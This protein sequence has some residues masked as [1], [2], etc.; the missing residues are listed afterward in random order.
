MQ[1][2]TG[3]SSN[4]IMKIIS[5]VFV[6]STALYLSLTM[7]SA[8]A[9]SCYTEITGDN[10]TD[11]SS[12]DASALQYAI[13]AAASGDVIKVA[14][15]C[16]DSSSTT[17]VNP[18]VDISIQG[19]YSE[20]NWLENADPETNV[21]TLD[22]DNNGRIVK[23]SNGITLTLSGVVLSNVNKGTSD[24]GAIYNN[25]GTLILNDSTITGSD[26]GN[27]GA[28]FGDGSSHI[29]AEN[30]AIVDNK[31]NW[32][33]VLYLENSSTGEFVNST[34]SG[35]KTTNVNYGN[36]AGFYLD[37]T[38]SL[39][40]TAVTISNNEASQYG[41]AIFTT[42]SSSVTLNSTIIANNIDADACYQGYDSDTTTWTD[43]GY[44]IEST[45]TC[46]LS[47]SNSL[48]DTDPLLEALASNGGSTQTHA[49]KDDSPAID[50]I[51]AGDND[52]GYPMTTDQRGVR[53]PQ[54]NGCDIGA[55]EAD[56]TAA[57]FALDDSYSAALYATLN[58]EADA[59]LLSNDLGEN[60]SA[61]LASAASHG[62]VTVNSDGSFSYTADGTHQ[63]DDSF[64]Y[65]VSDG[66]DS[67]IATVSIS[68]GDGCYVETT[69]DD[70]SDDASN[71]ASALQNAITAASS[72]DVIKIAG[73]CADSSNSNLVNPS[74]DI[75]LQG[76]YDPQGNWLVDADP[77]TYITTL[78]AEG[79]GRVVNISSGLTLTLSGLV[80]TGA[81]KGTSD[82]GAIYNNGGTLMLS[83]STVTDSDAGEGGAYFGDASSHIYAENVAIIDN[84]VVWNGILYFENSST[85][86]FV[87]STISGNKT[88][89]VNYGNGAGFYLADTASL[90]LNFVTISNNDASQ[91]GSAIFTTDSASVSLSNTLIANNID[92][93]ACYQGYSSDATNWT[94]NGYNLENSDSCELNADT[95]LVST[96]PLLEALADN[97]G[98][99]KTH[100]LPDS[101]PALNL[102]A[103]GVNGCGDIYTRDQRGESRPYGNCDI[104]A[105]EN[106]SVAP[107]SS[108]NSPTVSAVNIIGTVAA[109]ATLTGSYTYS[110]AD[111]DV[112]NGSVY[113]WY[114]ADSAI[115][116]ASSSTYTLSDNDNGNSLKFCITPSDGTNSGTQ[117]C[118]SSLA[119][120]WTDSNQS[121]D[122][123]TLG[124]QS[125]NAGFDKA[126]LFNG[127]N[128]YAR[129]ST[130]SGINPAN[131][132]FTAETWFKIDALDGTQH[133]M[134]QLTN[135]GTGRTWL[136][137]KSSGTLYTWLGGSNLEGSTVISEGQWH[138]A[139]VS[140]AKDSSTLS[141]Y[142]DGVLVASDV[143]SIESSEG[144][145]VLGINKNLN[146]AYLDGALDETRLWLET[147]SQDTLQQHM[148]LSVLADNETNLAFHF[149]YDQDSGTSL[150]DSKNA[151][152]AVF[153]SSIVLADS[154]SGQMLS[155]DGNG[156]YVEVSNYAG[157]TGTSA[158]TV[159]AWIRTTAYKD[160][161]VSWGIKSSGQK[162]IMRVDSNGY[163]RTE[164]ADGHI[165]GDVFIADGAWHHVA[166]SLDD[167]GSP[168]IS[169]AKLY[170]DGVLNN[171]Q[172]VSTQSIDTAD[173]G[174]VQIGQD[175][176]NRYFAG[177]IDDVR[178]WDDVRSQAEIEANMSSRLNGDEA[179]LTAYYHFENGD[180]S[181]ASG[182]NYNGALNADA[183]V[184]QRGI[185]VAV[186]GSGTLNGVVPTSTGTTVYLDT[187]PSL[188]SVELLVD[189][190]FSYTPTDSSTTGTDHFSY[191]VTDD[192]NNYSYSETVTITLP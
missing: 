188:G 65:S 47:S 38:A 11:Y 183:N 106:Q 181:D 3:A 69:G 19:G 7:T 101:S 129:I 108:N 136:G 35:N 36:G 164:V 17:I 12:S 178:I 155:L 117:T 78:D 119:I 76:G 190:S 26:A 146:G 191:L 165:T 98:N 156:D 121:I 43:D 48:S 182:N 145:L 55:Y 97:G 90:S 32:N 153:N 10:V 125:L 142:L 169:E 130:N 152:T 60:L 1:L 143:R 100:A 53:R 58:V 37:D 163:L 8:H 124:E 22:A 44:N 94:D 122:T 118:S 63:G 180:A 95:S 157:V 82:G 73:T 45:N 18:S 151:Y 54:D 49:L 30:V 167:D 28:Y 144:D 187:A 85:A 86:E 184:E 40:L 24:A 141:L 107:V 5:K 75:T 50:L 99:H 46:G 41:S 96:D 148:N 105:Y 59:G 134:Q 170:V 92:A 56:G 177:D 13:T 189:G 71:D 114:R 39:T 166:V 79:K 172:S 185:P 2:K 160:A 70:V 149:Q 23:I 139:A 135:N 162:W 109:N 64:S 57:G 61:A 21:T 168:N 140:Y 102:I 159:E 128:D 133:L 147:R 110:D 87:N 179:N 131:I 15:T 104:G 67:S 77:K 112:E 137:V 83:D 66:T 68:I 138:H 25:G 74:V 120:A 103:Y 175:Q 34:I 127:S 89:N 31:V 29:Y 81:D 80:L 9:D 174:T 116:G 132:D 113:Q 51:A 6:L 72:G 14:G 192:A 186:S 173:T 91:Y 111:S 126:L 88:T 171:T 4:N 52:C 27:G 161:I 16:T 154:N 150:N 84:K 93:D 20:S 115:D 62:S 158:R 123:S 42:A 176:H 33:G